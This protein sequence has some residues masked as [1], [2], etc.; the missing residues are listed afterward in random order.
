MICNLEYQ[1]IRRWIHLKKKLIISAKTLLVLLNHVHSICINVVHYNSILWKH[2]KHDCLYD[3]LLK[4][5]KSPCIHFLLIKVLY[6]HTA[7]PLDLYKWFKKFG[8]HSCLQICKCMFP[9][10][11]VSKFWWSFLW[12]SCHS[13]TAIILVK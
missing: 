2:S 11:T 5:R 4:H 9:A 8:N 7:V 13:L 10:L 6:L 12:E 1:L 3:C